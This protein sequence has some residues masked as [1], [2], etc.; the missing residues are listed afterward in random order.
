[1]NY[2]RASVRFAIN[3]NFILFLLWTFR[4]SV[5]R[6]SDHWAVQSSPKAKPW[7]RRTQL[8]LLFCRRCDLSKPPQSAGT[9][10]PLL[11]SLALVPPPSVS[12]DQVTFALPL[13][14]FQHHHHFHWLR[15]AFWLDRFGLMVILHLGQPYECL[16]TLAAPREGLR[17]GVLHVVYWSMCNIPAGCFC[18]QE[19]GGQETP[20]GGPGRRH[21]YLLSPA[22]L[23]RCASWAPFSLGLIGRPKLNSD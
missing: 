14:S 17:K 10:T 7:W 5:A 3:I 22:I 15:V 2:H 4:W 16:V 8:Q 18:N 9:S 12:L 23:V 11:S 1:M 13:N 20:V 19:A 21:W 6:T